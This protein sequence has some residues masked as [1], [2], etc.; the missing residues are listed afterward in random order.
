MYP[1]SYESVTE[2][3]NDYLRHHAN[4]FKNSNTMAVSIL[5]S[6]ES[7]ALFKQYRKNKQTNNNLLSRYKHQVRYEE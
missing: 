1:D 4:Y 3:F 5:A 2:A 7:L 6:K